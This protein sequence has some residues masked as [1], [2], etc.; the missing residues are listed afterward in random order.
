MAWADFRSPDC[1]GT[2]CCMYSSCVPKLDQMLGGRVYISSIELRTLRLIIRTQRDLLDSYW[3]V[4]FQRIST[5][6]RKSLVDALQTG[7]D[8]R[9]HIRCSCLPKQN[10][11]IGIGHRFLYSLK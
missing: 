7:Q 10:V 11:A 1:F 9:V 3:K 6:S 4:T 5:T 2:L 8:V